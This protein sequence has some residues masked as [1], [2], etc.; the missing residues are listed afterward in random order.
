V[1]VFMFGLV[2][3]SLAMNR[4]LRRAAARDAAGPG[5]KSLVGLD[6]AVAVFAAGLVFVPAGLRAWGADWAVQAVTFGLVAAAGVLAGLVFPLAA[7]VAL[8]RQGDVVRA[9]AA[10]DAA[11]HV[12]ACLGAL[13]TGTLLVPVL[14]ISGSCLTVAAVKVLSALVVGAAT[15]RRTASP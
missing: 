2:L 8:K 10:V 7:A 1:G 4:R 6:L 5:L 14:G 3:G 15:V 9:A 13:V 12:G 11:D